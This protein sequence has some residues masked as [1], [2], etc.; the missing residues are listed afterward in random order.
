M[1]NADFSVRRS[2]TRGGAKEL[3]DIA[4][5]IIKCS[6]LDNLGDFGRGQSAVDT[7]E[8]RG[9]TG[10]VR[11]G[12]GSPFHG[13]GPSAREGGNDIDSG[14]PDIN[15]GTIIGARP[16]RVID[17]RSGDGD[18]LLK[19]GRRVVARILVG[20]SCGYD[21][22]D[23][24]VVKLK[25]ESYVSS[26]LATFH[27]LSAHIFNGVVDSGIRITNHAY[28][29]NRGIASPRCLIGDPINAGDTVVR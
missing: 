13:Y 26:V 18:R 15:D 16:L 24:T 19:A 3:T 28:R 23:T 11:T 29:S 8:A 5:S 14:S 25:M 21:D 9:E 20:I 7:E 27:P 17:I 4:E 22:G 1:G 2:N 12:H 6:I 10:N